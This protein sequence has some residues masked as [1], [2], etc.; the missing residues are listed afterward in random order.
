MIRFIP[1]FNF[2]LFLSILYLVD[3]PYSPAYIGQLF[4]ILLLAYRFSL[5][6]NR[7]I[8][9]IDVLF[10]FAIIIVLFLTFLTGSNDP[11]VFLNAIF[12][13]LLYSM[14]RC[15]NLDKSEIISISKY[16]VVFIILITGCE[17][18]YR[19]TNPQYYGIISKDEADLFFYPYKRNSFMF[20]DSNYTSIL[21][22]AALQVF[23]FDLVSVKKNRNYFL[24]LIFLLFLTFSRASIFSF[25]LMFIFKWL[26]VSK[27]KYKLYIS[28]SLSLILAILF[29]LIFNVSINV[30]DGSFLSKFS[31]INELTNLL[32][33]N[34][35]IEMFFGLGL[36]ASRDIIGVGAHN[37]LVLMLIEFGLIF[38]FVFV[39]FSFSIL[40]IGYRY[41]FIFIFIFFING[42]SLGFFFPFVL[43][44]IALRLSSDEM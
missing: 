24:A 8:I 19:I 22:L 36:G 28:C 32:Y 18:V 38:T 25:I 43:F 20:L 9:P 6:N 3:A 31:I 40:S 26:I 4:C 2:S 13:F 39:L 5:S 44:P 29:M 27:N 14:L 15:S 12:T 17:T 35:N 10:S 21:I 11:G 42:F 30:D 16:F 33:Y 34:F 7:L 41:G 1:I 23:L 37:I